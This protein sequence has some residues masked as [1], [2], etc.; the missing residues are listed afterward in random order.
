MNRSQALM[1]LL[2]EIAGTAAIVYHRTGAKAFTDPQTGKDFSGKEV[3][4]NIIAQGFAEGAEGMYGPGIY[5]TY[6]LDSQFR[7]YMSTY[8]EYLVKCRV[9]L[10]GYIIL[11]YAEARKVY[12]DAYP[13]HNQLSQ[14]YA[15]RWLDNEAEWIEHYE[16]QLRSRPHET[17]SKI[18]SRLHTAYHIEGVVPGMLF[19]GQHDDA[20][21]VTY[22]PEYILPVA[23]AH[24]PVGRKTTSA[25]TPLNTV[26]YRRH[27]RRAGLFMRPLPGEK[28]GRS[29]GF[30]VLFQELG[31]V[32]AGRP[33]GSGQAITPDAD[34]ISG[35]GL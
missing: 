11:D 5:A 30:S 25:W 34:K 21:V 19:T 2:E 12:R 32:T 9:N 29:T 10:Q 15:P 3:P 28:I 31:W 14:Y 24:Q 23:Y 27:V 13:L 6:R 22:K 1:T 16:T 26:T 8:G 35:N 20:V 33:S 17:T 7:D 4:E 18:A